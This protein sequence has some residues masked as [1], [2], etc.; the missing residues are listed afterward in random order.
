MASR[1]VIGPF[2]V[3]THDWRWTQWISLFVMAI[4]WPLGLFGQE[5]CKYAILKRRRARQR[6]KPRD[7][8]ELVHRAKALLRATVTRPLNMLLVEPIVTF[9]SLY[10]A[11]DIALCY[12]FF[13]SYGYVFSTVYG[14]TPESQGLIFLGMAVG[15]VVGGI[16]IALV[17]LWSRAKMRVK[18]QQ[19]KESNGKQPEDGLYNAMM[20][21]VALPASLFWFAWSA[22]PSVHWISPV[23]ASAVFGWADI[24]I[25]VSPTRMCPAHLLCP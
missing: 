14:L 4:L 16:T 1:S 6:I 17:D 11:F 10:L 25:Y 22:R 3:T 7:Q 5:T 23:I 9:F 12:S 13:S 20:G 21:S 18:I 15:Y 2:A 24:L 8:G 19:G